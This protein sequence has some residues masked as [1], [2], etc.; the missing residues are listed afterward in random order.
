MKK[1]LVIIVLVFCAGMILFACKKEAPEKGTVHMETR[2]LAGTEMETLQREKL[3]YVA[4]VNEGGEDPDFVAVVGVDPGDPSTYGKIIHRVDMLHVG[5]ELHHFGYNHDKTYLMVPGLFSGR[6][7]IVDVSDP[8]HPVIKSVYENLIKESG[9]T[10]P[11]TIIGLENG[12]NLVTMIGANTDST[13]PGGVVELNGETGKFVSAF[14]PT[15][16]RDFNKIPPKYM[17]DAGIKLELNRMVTTSFGLPKHVGPG[18]TIDGLGTDIYVW[19]WKERRVVQT[20]HIGAGTGALEVRWRAEEGSTIGYTNAP[21]SDEI[22]AWDDLD[23]DGTFTFTPVIKLP[24]G[25][26]PTDMLLTDDDKYIY[27]SNWMGNNVRQYN[28][29]DPLKPILVSEVE[30]PYAQMLRLS[31]DKKRLY[32]SN[33]LL[34][35]WDDTEF[36]KGTTRNEQYGIF[37]VDV[38]HEKGKMTLNRDFHVDMMNIQKKNTVGPARPHMMLFDPTIQSPFGHH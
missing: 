22:W 28:I 5:D 7:Y 3:L 12:N 18:I 21:G 4:C 17:Y 30:I 19:D 16:N 35:T 26:I 8:K 14:G 15:A 9:Y 25:S 37:L 1:S 10:T 34:S 6:I 36:P 27:V 11:H 2:K 24:E 38:D 33:S 23:G 20:E 32:V 29:E 31:P 13:A